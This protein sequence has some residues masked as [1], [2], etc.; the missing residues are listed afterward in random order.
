MI[1][2]SSKYGYIDQTD[3][4]VIKPQFEQAKDFENGQAY[5]EKKRFIGM[6]IRKGYIDKTGEW[7]E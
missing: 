5:V 2:K 3:N 6:G 7:I 4:I 1:Y